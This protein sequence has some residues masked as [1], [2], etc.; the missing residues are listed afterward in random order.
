MK[1]HRI[2]LDEVDWTALDRFSDR[3]L[4]Q[5]RQWLRFLQRTQGAEPVIARVEDHGRLAGFFTGAIVRKF[6]VK[7]LGSPFRGWT[8]S[9]MG[10]NMCDDADRQ[11]ALEALPEFAF[12][13]LRCL[14]VEILDRRIDGE[15]ARRAGY[16]QTLLSWYEIDL[17]QSEDQLFRNMESACRRCI[18]KA[19][20]SGVLIEEATDIVGFSDDYYAQ[21][22]DVFLKQQLVPTYTKA[23]VVALLE[24]LE[25]PTNLLLLRA[26]DAAGTCIATA[27]FPAFGDTSY[28]W[29]GASWRAHQSVRPNEALHWYAMRYWKQR[30]VTRY[31]MGGGGD[32]KAKYGGTTIALPWMSRS[33]YPIVA[34]M[35]SRARRLV[36]ASQRFAGK[37][38]AWIQERRSNAD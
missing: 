22:E 21:L 9:Y 34:Y 30:G 36:K 24:T 8:T 20:K 2:A 28:F 12:Q 25:R 6:G 32:Y 31:D 37:A 5:T 13:E 17:A 4:F 10:F 18:R 23:R 11:R 1:L 29:G 19:E 14:H 35:R 38:T 3:T 16:D 33:R 7:I 15:A 27:I 26:R